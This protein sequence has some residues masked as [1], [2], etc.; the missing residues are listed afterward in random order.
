MIRANTFTVYLLCLEKYDQGPF[1]IMPPFK[2]DRLCCI[3]F[4]NF[5][6][7]TFLL[8]VITFYQF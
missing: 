5:S 2:I 7:I 6:Q 1:V 8:I 3:V 4:E